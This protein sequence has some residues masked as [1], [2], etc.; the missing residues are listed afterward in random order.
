MLT[1]LLLFIGSNRQRA[2]DQ[3]SKVQ[4]AAEAFETRQIKQFRSFRKKLL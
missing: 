3:P 2:L 4:I 1:M